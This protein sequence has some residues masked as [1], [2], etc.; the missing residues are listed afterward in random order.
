MADQGNL[1]E[2][3]SVCEWFMQVPHWGKMSRRLSRCTCWECSGTRGSLFELRR[4]TRPRSPCPLPRPVLVQ[5]SCCNHSP[6]IITNPAPLDLIY[7]VLFSTTI[8][9][10]T[11]TKMMW[12]THSD[13]SFQVGNHL[14]SINILVPYK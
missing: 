3:S 8:Y 10:K 6:L 1:S 11:K 7:S 4:A 2:M 14:K 12:A 9:Q 13:E 5:A